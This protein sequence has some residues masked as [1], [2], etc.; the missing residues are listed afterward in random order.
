[1]AKYN[2]VIVRIM[3][4]T[5]N[6]ELAK[7]AYK[8]FEQFKKYKNFVLAVDLVHQVDN[9]HILHHYTEDELNWIKTL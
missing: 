6:L 3:L 8:E 1:V 9:G 4:D 5:G 7:E 2:W